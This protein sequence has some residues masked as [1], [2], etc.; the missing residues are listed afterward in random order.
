MAMDIAIVT[1]HGKPAAAS[2]FSRLRARAPDAAWTHEA[3]LVEHHGHKDRLSL[4][5]TV[6]GHYVSLDESDHV[7]QPRAAV[8][9]VAGGVIG[10][11]LG[12]PFGLAPGLVLGALFGAVSGS[13]PDETEAGFGTLSEQLRAAVPKGSSAI[14]VLAEPAHT[15]ELVALVADEDAQ[16]TCRTLTPAELDAIVAAVAAAPSASAGPQAGGDAHAGGEVTAA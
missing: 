10:T 3:A 11:A 6:A 15:D 8:G 12:G 4:H 1:F 5:G 2:A 13:H 9:A 14:V 16:V 7:S